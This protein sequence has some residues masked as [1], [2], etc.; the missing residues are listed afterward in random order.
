MDTNVLGFSAADVDGRAR[1][2]VRAAPHDVPACRGLPALPGSRCFNY[3]R[4]R[5]QGGSTFQ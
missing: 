2:S 4:V 5:E 3:E 1:H